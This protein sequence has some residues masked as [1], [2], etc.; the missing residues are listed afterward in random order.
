MYHS[1]YS[2][3]LLIPYPYERKETKPM[4]FIFDYWQKNCLWLR[5]EWFRANN[6]VSDI[7]LIPR[8]FPRVQ[9][10]EIGNFLQIFTAGH[11]TGSD[12]GLIFEWALQ[13]LPR[14]NKD[15]DCLTL[16]CLH[17]EVSPKVYP[18]TS[19]YVVSSLIDQR[20]IV[21]KH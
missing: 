15:T 4:H 1:Q 16:V 5:I 7:T 14:T 6:W 3:T 17:E 20:S 10:L 18:S 12:F 19:S 21:T 8:L 11:F 2:N 13:V 9:R